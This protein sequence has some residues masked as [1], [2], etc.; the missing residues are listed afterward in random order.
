MVGVVFEMI[1]QKKGSQSIVKKI[2]E[3]IDCNLD[4]DITRE[5]LAK[6]VFL[7]PD[8]LSRIFKKEIGESIGNYIIS[9][10]METAKEYL[11][12]TNEPVNAVAVKVGYDNFS[13]FSKVFKNYVG[14][15]PKEYKANIKK[16]Q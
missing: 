9:K 7:N 12:K 15:T 2:K 6:S 8:Y 3:Y 10:R 4:K 13:Y 5:S 1:F 16:M 11:E 14:T